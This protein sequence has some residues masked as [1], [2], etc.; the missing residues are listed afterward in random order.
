MWKSDRI[1]FYEVRAQDERYKVNI[2]K[3]LNNPLD[4]FVTVGPAQGVVSNYCRTIPTN[5]CGRISATALPNGLYQLANGASSSSCIKK[6]RQ[7]NNKDF[8]NQI[9]E[10]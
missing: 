8:L 4:E 9:K 3:V 7:R 10:E 5:G 6:S 1:F 2:S